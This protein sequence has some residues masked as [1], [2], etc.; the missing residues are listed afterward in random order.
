MS[1][2]KEKTKSKEERLLEIIKNNPG[3]SFN[4]LINLFPY[5]RGTL[6]RYLKILLGKEEIIK[7][8]KRYYISDKGESINSLLNIP[9]MSSNS[10]KI[11]ATSIAVIGKY[12]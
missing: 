7:K 5:S 8:A 11:P 1:I 6:N 12:V 10:P 2:M 3:E 4:I 9:K